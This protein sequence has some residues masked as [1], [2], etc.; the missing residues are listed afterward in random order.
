MQLSTNVQSMTEDASGNIWVT[1]A[2]EVLM[3]LSTH[4]TPQHERTIR[5]PTGAWRV[6]RDSRGQIWAAAFGGGLMRVRDPLDTAAIIERYEYEH[7]LAGSPRSL[8]EDRE[9]NI[10]V[11]MRGGL[12]RLSESSFTNV[13]QLEG[14]TNEG[15][16]TATV[17]SDGS[18]WVATG[19]GLN[20]FSPSGRTSYS[21]SQT[22]ALHSDRRGT[23][24][25]S[26]AGQI[27][28][29]VN[30]RLVP[31]DV[32]D[33]IRKSRVMAFTTDLEN[34]LWLCTALKGVMTWDGKTVTTVRGEGRHRRSRVS[35][36]LHGQTG[37][38]VDRTALR[39]SRR[40]RQGHV[41]K[42]RRERR[43]HAVEL[44]S[45]FSRTPKAPSGS[46]TSAGVSR[47]QN[48]RVTAVTQD[49]APLKDLVPVLIE[50]LEGQIWV[51]VNSGAAVIRFHPSE[52]D[53][54][55]GNPT[56]QLEYS[57]FDE[58]DGMQLG[59]QT[60][61]A[62][63]GGVRGGDGR[64]WVATGLGMTVIDPTQPSAV[65]SATASAYRR[66]RGRR[67]PRLGGSRPLAGGR[68]VEPPNRVRHHQPV[69]VLEAPLPVH[70]RRAG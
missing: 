1:D 6:M 9:G 19:H 7:R 48:G 16:R 55:A 61:Q 32:P 45:R 56:Y 36:D 12:I 59:S 37:S 24:W 17:G 15:V 40:L 43:A 29:F 69:I 51:G 58:T 13:T 47:I 33:V 68:D 10:W 42:L 41:Q 25:V 21:V 30:G 3:R 44:S 46:A 60:W 8:Y 2:Q 67:P 64:L 27:S 22:M 5:L 11:G 39:R 57:L 66:N 54:I 28:Q 53:K 38:S 34:N 26:A 20:R 14:L 18:V 4:S 63:V 23:L 65:A 70:A 62:G 50:D 49:N 35:V 31:V 52:V